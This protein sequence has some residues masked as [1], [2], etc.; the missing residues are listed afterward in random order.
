M[1]ALP[2]IDCPS[3]L[4]GGLSPAQFM[5]RHW[6]KQPLLVR[7]ALPGLA[8]GHE[9]SPLSRQALFD[10]AAREEVPSRLVVRSGTGVGV[11]WQ[12]QHGPFKRRVLPPLRQPAWTLL[13]QGTDRAHPAMHALLQRFAFVPA[14]RLDDVMVSYASPGGG[15]G[16]HVDSY[17]VF[18]LQVHGEREWRIGQHADLSLRPGLP[19]KILKRFKATQR[20]VLKP[21]DMLYLPP[22]WAHD[23]VALG[24]CMTC[25]IGFRA[26]SRQEL[27]REVLGRLGEGREG[28]NDTERYAD[29]TQPAVADPAAL[30]VKLVHTAQRW[31][32]EALREPGGVSRALGEYLSEPPDAV[33]FA[34]PEAPSTGGRGPRGVLRLDSSTR[35]LYDADH[36]FINGESVPWVQLQAQDTPVLKAFA[37]SRALARGQRAVLSAAARRTL[38]DW[39]QAGWAHEH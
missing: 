11:A 34:G 4:L 13:V 16:P 32:A 29:P 36:L 7:G 35:M 1:Q 28:A 21:G 37:N 39:V 17:D 15:V 30:P 25:S 22:N 20:W 9:P 27:V 33:W 2:S 38:D 26:P 10:L 6:H 23:G 12:V 18:L 3:P 31:L 19:L 24:E 8:A 5:R 14:A